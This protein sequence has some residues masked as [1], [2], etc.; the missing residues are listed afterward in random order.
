VLCQ[1]VLSI[2]HQLAQ[3]I[4]TVNHLIQTLQGGNSSG[5]VLVLLQ[6]CLLASMCTN[7]SDWRLFSGNSSAFVTWAEAVLE[8]Y[9]PAH[10]GCCK[11]FLCC[12]ARR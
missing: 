2:S 3:H 8:G 9:S 5:G 4:H 6:C 12:M 7:T 1:A 11:L 10:P